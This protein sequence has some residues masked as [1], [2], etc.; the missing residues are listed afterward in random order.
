[1]KIRFSYTKPLL[2][3]AFMLNGEH[4]VRGQ[5]SLSDPN[6]GKPSVGSPL[7]LSGPPHTSVSG[8]GPASLQGHKMYSRKTENPDPH[9][10]SLRQSG[11]KL[12]HL[13]AKLAQAISLKDEKII[14]EVKGEVKDALNEHFAYDLA[15]RET[16]TARLIK[17]ADSAESQNKQ[18]LALKDEL[19]DLQLQSYVM[20]KDSLA[21]GS[22]ELDLDSPSLF[23]SKSETTSNDFGNRRA[24]SLKSSPLATPLSGN[25]AD[26]FSGLSVDSVREPQQNPIVMIEK[27]RLKLATVA[28]VDEESQATKEL[29]EALGVYYLRDLEERDRLLKTVRADIEKMKQKLEKRASSEN[30]I[31][32]LQFKLFV[33]EASGLGFFSPKATTNTDSLLADPFAADPSATSTISTDPFR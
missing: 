12:A 32:E 30:S 7:D 16:V 20:E 31:V 4:A 13:K 2:T 14:A 3:L 19:I 1:M 17:R 26:P 33:N 27:A 22:S 6:Y 10:K 15:L 25:G 21:V 24:S 28:S 8:P 5:I 9:A 23:G 18:R 29:R 11:E